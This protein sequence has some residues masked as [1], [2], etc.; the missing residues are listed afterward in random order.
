M[1][2]RSNL[3]ILQSSTLTFLLFWFHFVILPEG[4]K[5]L[6]TAFLSIFQWVLPS[7]LSKLIHLYLLL[8]RSLNGQWLATQNCLEIFVDHYFLTLV[9]LQDFQGLIWI[10]LSLSPL[11]F[12]LVLQFHRYFYRQEWSLTL[13]YLFYLKVDL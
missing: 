11:H 12:V 10:P 9:I 13:G 1:P 6:S 8:W 5:F 3:F 4:R 2:S 7:F